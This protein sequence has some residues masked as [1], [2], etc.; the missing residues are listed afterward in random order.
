MSQTLFGRSAAGSF[1]RSPAGA[2]T[3][4]QSRLWVLGKIMP[5]TTS[6]HQKIF[7]IDSTGA[8]VNV[9][10]GPTQSATNIL[11]NS[12]IGSDGQQLLYT[13]AEGKRICKLN[14]TTFAITSTF[15]TP[16]SSLIMGT[17]VITTNGSYAYFKAS[18]SDGSTK[19]FQL[20]I[21]TMSVLQSVTLSVFPFHYQNTL[22]MGATSSGLWLVSSAA[23]APTHFYL[24]HFDLNLNFLSE[25]V[26]DTALSAY[27]PFGGLP[28]ISVDGTDS[29]L[30]ILRGNG[31]PED[32]HIYNVNSAGAGLGLTALDSSFTPYHLR[33][34]A[35]GK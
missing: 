17:P 35:G 29:Q 30:R 28:P 15:T 25:I 12:S 33:S 10:L 34:I 14:P 2:K 5:P 19:L 24:G 20:D 3:L 21:N 11:T 18:F 27:F 22:G 6:P 1:I 23:F 13:D 26:L 32:Y 4:G 9:G 7:E 16:N 8:F 31:S